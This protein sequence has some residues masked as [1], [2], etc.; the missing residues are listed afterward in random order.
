[1]PFTIPKIDPEDEDTQVADAISSLPPETTDRNPS[2][3]E[4]KLLEGVGTFYGL[5]T[6][7][8][9]QIPDSLKL[10]VFN[11]VGLNLAAGEQ[12]SDLEAR[13][14][15]AFESTERAISAVSFE[16]MAQ[17]L[18]GVLR[19]RATGN[20]GI[21]V[22]H[23]LA[24][25]LNQ[26]S[27]ATLREDTRA[28]LKA[29]TAPGIV[30]VTNQ[31]PTRLVALDEVEIKFEQSADK[32]AVLSTIVDTFAAYVSASTW[33]WGA[34]LWGNE[35]VSMFSD[36][37]GVS[38]VGQITVQFTDDYGAIWTPV[39]LDYSTPITPAAPEDFGVLQDGKDYP[40]APIA[41]TAY[42]V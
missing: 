41:T 21:V 27:D 29:A 20:G 2:S 5:L 6:Y 8:A 15:S 11:L 36:I 3:V 1:M 38:R 12:V 9:D 22:V 39:T 31:Y 10:A 37:E 16:A 13:A 7:F 40:G 34:Y 19:A 24:D 32:A 25:D 30:V 17:G 35:L 28:T 4:V 33:P 18:D 14:P 26:V 42:L 23:L